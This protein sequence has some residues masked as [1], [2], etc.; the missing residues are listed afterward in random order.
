M[1]TVTDFFN[2]LAKDIDKTYF[3]TVKYY[4]DDKQ[5]EKVHYAIER[6]NNGCLSYNKLIEEISKACNEEK[7]YIN[8]IVSKY[9]E[10]FGEF[11]PKY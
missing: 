10:D 4:R 2:K 7:R 5:C 1:V 3:P 8:L 9:V 11:V 6:F